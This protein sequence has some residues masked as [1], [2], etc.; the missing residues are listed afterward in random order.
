MRIAGTFDPRISYSPVVS[1]SSAS[2]VRKCRSTTL[3]GVEGIRERK[4]DVGRASPPPRP[5]DEISP[6]RQKRKEEEGLD[7]L[8]MP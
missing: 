6:E 4:G 1:T 2:Q 7:A 5:F 8:E 3:T